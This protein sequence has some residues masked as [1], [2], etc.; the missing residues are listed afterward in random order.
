MNYPN[1][2]QWGIKESLVKYIDSLKD[3]EVTLEGTVERKD[4]LFTFYIDQN[5]S[6]FDPES[7]EGVLQFSGVVTFTG[8]FGAMNIRVGDPRIILKNGKGLLGVV[9]ESVFADPRIDPIVLLTVTQNDTSI[10][11][12]TTL[13]NEGQMFFGPQYTPGQEMSP[14]SIQFTH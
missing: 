12:R 7:F 8:Y 5:A 3:G 6:K 4:D 14:L 1:T 2:L 9:V 13:T 10:E 11:C